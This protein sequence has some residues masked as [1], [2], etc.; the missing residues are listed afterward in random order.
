MLRLSKDF[1]FVIFILVKE[2]HSLLF[3]EKTRKIIFPFVTYISGKGQYNTIDSD[4]HA[5]FQV[6]KDHN[7]IQAIEMAEKSYIYSVRRAANKQGIVIPEDT[8][9]DQREHTI[10]VIL[11]SRATK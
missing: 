8:V 9:R 6:L 3:W 10:N 7:S 1:P 4:S 2:N 11:T 5:L